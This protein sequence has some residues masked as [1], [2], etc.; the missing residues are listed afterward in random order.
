MKDDVFCHSDDWRDGYD[1]GIRAERAQF[2]GHLISSGVL[3]PDRGSSALYDPLKSD[4]V[5][6]SILEYV[7]TVSAAGRKNH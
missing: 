7:D 1:T 3:A 6:R 4:M 5:R 2:I